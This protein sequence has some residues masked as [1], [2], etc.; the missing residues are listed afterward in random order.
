MG[1]KKKY[2]NAAEKQRAWR[3]RH[4]QPRKVP[5]RIR[6]GEKLGGSEAYLRDREE[7]ESWEDY[8]KYLRTRVAKARAFKSE[9]LPIEREG[10]ESVGAKRAFGKYKEPF[11]GESYY[12][13]QR[14]HEISLEKATASRRNRIKKKRK[15]KK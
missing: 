12:E 15:T 10:E 6:V 8:D 13:M 5:L 9:Q 3:I 14:E 1:R 4:G 11:M 2:K 7:G